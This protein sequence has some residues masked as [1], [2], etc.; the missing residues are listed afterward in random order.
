MLDSALAEKRAKESLVGFPAPVTEAYL[1]FARTGDLQLLDV[2]VLGVL[3]FYLAKKPV[4]ALDAMP[5]TTRLMDDLG[6]DSLTMM[7]TVFTV[8]SLFDIKIDDTE[9]MQI[10]TIDDL[11]AKLRQH[12]QA[13]QAPTG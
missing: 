8:E 6:C 10:A 4:G 9:L 3:R 13:P 5:G 2:V 12:L 11:R 7:D 1:T